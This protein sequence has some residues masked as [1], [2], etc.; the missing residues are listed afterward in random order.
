MFKISGLL[1]M[2]INL[3][4]IFKYVLLEPTLLTRI[5][6]DAHTDVTPIGLSEVVIQ[7]VLD[8]FQPSKP[9]AFSAKVR[10]PTVKMSVR[11]KKGFES[12]KKLRGFAIRSMSKSQKKAKRT[13]IIAQNPPPTP[14]KRGRPRK[15]IQN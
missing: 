2:V 4:T 1:Y 8:L 3:A 12:R 15:V 13:P 6:F 10:L 7:E 9:F 5:Y 11:E 14:A